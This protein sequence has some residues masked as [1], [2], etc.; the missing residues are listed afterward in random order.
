[1]EL[2]YIYNA[3]GTMLPLQ[4]CDLKLERHGEKGNPPFDYSFFFQAG[5]F[6]LNK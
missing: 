2:G 3:D 1:M 5:K 6:I 4:W